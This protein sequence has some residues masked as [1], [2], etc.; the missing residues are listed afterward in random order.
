MKTKEVNLGM[1]C[2]SC[3]QLSTH[4]SILKF[5][6]LSNSK[7]LRRAFWERMKGWATSEHE[8]ITRDIPSKHYV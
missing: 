6:I 3:E 1:L 8:N 5:Q 4:F 7:T 2:E